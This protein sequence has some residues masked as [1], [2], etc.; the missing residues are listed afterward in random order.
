MKI[1]VGESLGYSYLRHVK[2]CWLVQANWKAS[3]HWPKHKTDDELETMFLA[4]KDNFDRDGSVFKKTKDA[5]Q[6]LKQGEIDVVGVDLKGNVHAIEVAFH[7]GGLIYGSGPETRNR[8]LKKSL[9]TMLMLSAY[10]AP[11][12]KFHIYFAS[13][14]VNPR[15]QQKL[16]GVFCSLKAKYPDIDWNILINADF[17]KQLM[18]PTLEK[19]DTVADTSELFVR[20]AKL[21]GLTGPSALV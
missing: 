5:A 19:G 13:P 17:I 20:A 8:V 21:L 6:L 16:E 14:K 1:E 15:T 7:E 18:R 4:M 10:H 2:Q 3:E 9:R 11:G 12:T